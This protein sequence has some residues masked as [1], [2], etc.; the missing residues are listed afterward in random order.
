[1]ELAKSELGDRNYNAAW[2]ANAKALEAAPGNDA[3]RTQQAQIAMRWLE[4]MRLSSKPGAKTFGDIVEP[5][6]AALARYALSPR[7]GA[8]ELA[9]VKAHIGWARFLRS[10]DGVANLRIREEFD[11]ALATDNGNMYGHVLRG[12]VV[13]WEG[14]SVAAARADFD[15]ALES[16]TNPEFCDRMILA[17]FG[18]SHT[19]EHQLGA[20]DYANRMRKGRRVLG[21]EAKVQLLFVYEVGLRNPDYLIRLSRAVPPEEHAA[22]LA[23]L[24]EGL[25]SEDRRRNADALRAFF[26]EKSGDTGEAL[27]L[28]RE[29][30]ATSPD[31]STR[32][33]DLARAG[34]RRLA[35]A[36]TTTRS[37]DKPRGSPAR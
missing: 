7:L 28:Y 16:G 19:D 5:L 35:P 22:T 1:M 11:E 34:I 24:V 31:F 29:V 15:A 3:A 17:A 36:P 30:V 21:T 23:W 14:G 20:L 27:A 9:T 2:E 10:R 26:L 13:L 33:G 25:K 12:F 18:N 37:P 32:A 4:D 8:A 6:E